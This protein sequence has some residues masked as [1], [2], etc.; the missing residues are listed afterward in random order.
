MANDYIP[1]KMKDQDRSMDHCTRNSPINS[2]EGFKGS[3]R[4]CCGG[5]LPES[6]ATKKKKYRWVRDLEADKLLSKVRGFGPDLGGSVSAVSV[7]VLMVLV[8]DIKNSKK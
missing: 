6:L 4:P 3:L 7:R 2:K 1:Q 8:S 5:P